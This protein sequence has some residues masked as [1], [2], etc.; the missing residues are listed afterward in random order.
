M[1]GLVLIATAPAV[2]T[3]LQQLEARPNDVASLYAMMTQTAAAFPTPFSDSITGGP[4]TIFASINSAWANF[5]D[6]STMLASSDLTQLQVHN[7]A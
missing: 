4:Y 5:A 1:S 2:R 6:Y 3:L 7:N